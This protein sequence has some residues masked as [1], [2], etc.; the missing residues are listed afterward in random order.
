MAIRTLFLIMLLA[1]LPLLAATYDE[2]AHPDGSVHYKIKL[3][4]EG[5][6]HGKFVIYHPGGEAGAKGAKAE[7][8]AYRAGEL[9]GVVTRFDTDGTV[10]SEA[11]WVNGQ[12]MLP[13]TERLL[14]HRLKQ[15]EAEA[16]RAV[17]ALPADDQR[18]RPD[19][20]ILAAVLARTNHYRLLCGLDTDVVLDANYIHQ[21][22]CAA[23]VCAA[24]GKLDHHPKSN[25]GLSDDRWQAGRTGCGKSNLAMGR[26]GAGAVDMWIDDSDKSNRDR[27]GHRRWM[28]W[29]ELERMGYGESGRYSAAHVIDGKGSSSADVPAVRFPPAGLMPVAMFAPH[30]CWH[31]APDPKRY[32]VAKNARLVIRPYNPKTGE[33]GEPIALQFENVDFGGFGHRP[34]VIAQPEQLPLRPGAMFAV[35]VSGVTAK[36]DDAPALDWI[37]VFY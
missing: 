3:D 31:I 37:A 7:V 27:I 14:A 6:R 25:P 1:P 13:I 15:I 20:K 8:G 35:E 26:T 22:Q 21:G 19:A 9:H 18:P 23:E 4:R 5:R 2:T 28:L 33:R 10:L 17:A 24:L 11:M 36:Q 32:E 16:Q 12:C 34:A 30:Y 29:P